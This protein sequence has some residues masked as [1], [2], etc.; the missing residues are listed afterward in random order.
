M[1]GHSGSVDR[2]TNMLNELKWEPLHSRRRVN[3]FKNF[4]SMNTGNSTLE[5]LGFILNPPNFKGRNDHN[6][7]VQL[8]YSRKDDGKFSFTNRTSAE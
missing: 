5:E 4:H 7:K 3:R 1:L 8:N 6:Y 2:V